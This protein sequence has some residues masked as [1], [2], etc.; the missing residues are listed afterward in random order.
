[1]SE[2]GEFSKPIILEAIKP[3]AATKDTPARSQIYSEQKIRND[4]ELFFEQPDG[5]T[6]DLPIEKLQKELYSYFLTE[7]VDDENQA[8]E[9]LLS[10]KYNEW[11]KDD[12]KIVRQFSTP[13]AKKEFEHIWRLR[14][15]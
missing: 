6:A 13:E 2:K 15:I 7:E 3:Q 11:D 1:M 8:F 9:Y 12:R 14:H 4:Y 10:R 5:S